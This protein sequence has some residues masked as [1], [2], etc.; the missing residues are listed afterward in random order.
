MWPAS[1]GHRSV[2]MVT[3]AFRYLELFRRDSGRH[4]LASV[5]DGRTDIPIANTAHN[6]VA[7]LKNQSHFLS[8]RNGLV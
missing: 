8:Q 4:C 3:L 7:R 6:Y 1:Q 2:D 5:T